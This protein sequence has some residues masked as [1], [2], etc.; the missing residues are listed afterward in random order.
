MVGIGRRRDKRVVALLTDMDQP[1]GFAIGNALEIMEVSQTLQNL[2]P[3]DLREISI[4]L[5][6]RM[7]Y[8]GKIAPSLE[9]ARQTAEHL[10]ITGAGYKKFKEVIAA[11]GGNPKVLDQFE[12][13][14]NATDVREV[15]CP[16]TG[17]ISSIDAEL[18]GRASTMIGAGRDKKEDPIDPAVGII[19]EGKIGQRIEAGTV[20]CRIYITQSTDP[21]R[22]EEASE[23]IEDAFRI[24]QQPPD[25]RKV[26]LETV[27]I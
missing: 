2:G 12:L 8:L 7:I 10:L 5:A 1:L 23:L 27:S 26:I 13:L 11:Q 21:D 14:P 24:S 20:L 22:L 25:A 3:D 16:R 15:P 4:E 9:E 19:L 17:Y 6:A 18:V